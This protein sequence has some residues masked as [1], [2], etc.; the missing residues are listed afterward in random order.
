[1]I[2]YHSRILVFAAGIAGAAGVAMSAAAAHRGGA[3][4]ETAA[5]I[6]LVHAPA[7]LGL[8]LFSNRLARIGA[9]VL[10]AGMILFCGDLL[11]RDLAGERL[12]PNA[13]PAGGIL[14]IA[15]WLVVAA[16]AFT[17]RS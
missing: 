9:Y 5:T 1:M 7:L 14:V 11:S 10:I 4:L 8:A 15:G 2:G 13:A 17:S 6:L 16:S 12:F 3:N